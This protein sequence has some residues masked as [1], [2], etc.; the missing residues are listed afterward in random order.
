M[1][2]ADRSDGMWLWLAVG[3]C[4]AA[5]ALAVFHH[6]LR[7][8]QPQLP[9]EVEQFMLLFESE[10]SGHKDVEYVGL[11]PG[12]FAALLRVGGQDTPVSLH[13]LFRHAETFPS[14]FSAVVN[15]LV[16]EIR[17]VGLDRVGDHEFGAVATSILP[18]VR[19]CAWVES[20]GR[21]GDSALL[22]RRLSDDLAIVYVIDHPHAMV[23]LC[24]GHLRQWRRSEEDVH[25]L[26]LS[27]LQRIGAA[28]HL[29]RLA[30]GKPVIVQTGDG[31]DAARVLLLD[32]V[33]GLLVA[34][35]DRDMLWIGREPE[36]D[37]ANQEGTKSPEG[38]TSLMAAAESMARSAP[39]PISE[40]IYRLKDGLLEPVTTGDRTAP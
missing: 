16:A 11:L 37:A 3:W 36:S 29:Q 35:P 13:D 2:R 34:M 20:Q 27:N 24:R 17:E 4:A 22:Q 31:Y 9:A 18:Q 25:R 5:I 32:E 7:R 40:R 14:G 21:F 12:Q 30:D 28:D 26:A 38:L 6:R 19:S 39:H 15:Q 33:P 10:L 8:T 23:F 1:G